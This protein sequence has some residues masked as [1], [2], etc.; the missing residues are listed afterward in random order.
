[1]ETLSAPLDSKLLTCLTRIAAAPS[2]DAVW[3]ETLRYLDALGVSWVCYAY[4]EDPGT[5]DPRPAEKRTNLPGWWLERY[6]TMRYAVGDPAI[7]HTIRSIEPELLTMDAASDGGALSRQL[8]AESWS[9]LQARSTVVVPLRR[10]WRVPLGGV[11]CTTRLEGAAAARWY[12]A[13]GD[14]LRLAV[15]YA[16]V[17]LVEFARATEAATVRL[18]PRERECLLW[19][20]KGLRNDRI[21]ERMRI[22]RP[23]VEFHLMR[24]RRKLGATTRDQALARAVAFG[25]VVP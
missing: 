7:R 23:T 22:S 20:A 13:N 24:A 3:A 16:D 6:A 5:L 11:T 21:A 17:R 12:A 8:H 19:L 18:S 14:A 10:H 9:A 1:M 2:A 15:Y 25:L 4:A